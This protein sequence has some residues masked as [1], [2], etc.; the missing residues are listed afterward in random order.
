MTQTIQRPRPYSTKTI[1]PPAPEFEQIFIQHGW[2]KINR[3]FGKR[4]A[5]RWF[6][7][8]GAGRLKAARDAFVR[9]A[10]S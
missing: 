2:T 1:K 10:G 6:I 9:G 3:M 5:Q 7:M 8:L 4:C